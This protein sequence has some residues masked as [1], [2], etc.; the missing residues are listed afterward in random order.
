MLKAHL[1]AR[2]DVLL[3]GE[4]VSVMCG[5]EIKDAQVVFVW[6]SAEVLQKV[7]LEVIR[8]LCG[9]CRKNYQVV[10]G[11]TMLYAVCEGE[12]EQEL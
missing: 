4:T 8:G 11:R 12:S 1:I 6:D 7:D 10:V 3:H 5:K 2:E 9:K